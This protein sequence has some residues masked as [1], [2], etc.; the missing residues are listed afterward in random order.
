MISEIHAQFGRLLLCGPLPDCYQTFVCISGYIV[1]I[2]L[3]SFTNVGLTTEHEKVLMKFN[4]Y[5]MK[6]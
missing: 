3:D 6:S 5:R 1:L 4:S 2:S